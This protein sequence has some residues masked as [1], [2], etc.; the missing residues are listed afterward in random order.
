MPRLGIKALFFVIIISNIFTAYHTFSQVMRS[1]K[2]QFGISV[3]M[4]KHIFTAA[5]CLVTLQSFYTFFIQGTSV[6]SVL[7][8]M[9]FTVA[10]YILYGS[11]LYK[12][13]RQDMGWFMGRMFLDK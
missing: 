9:A 2:M 4:L 6:S 11:C 5:A 7:V 13:L 12:T 8:A 10:V 1:A 3:W